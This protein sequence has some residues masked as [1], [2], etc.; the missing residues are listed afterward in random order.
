MCIRDSTAG[1]GCASTSM[2]CSQPCGR[3]AALRT[4]ARRRRRRALGSRNVEAGAEAVQ[5]IATSFLGWRN[6]ANESSDYTNTLKDLALLVQ[7]VKLYG[8][9]KTCLRR[10]GSQT[11]LTS[12][13]YSS[14]LLMRVPSGVVWTL[15]AWSWIFGKANG[16]GIPNRHW[17]SR[18]NDYLVQEAGRTED[19]LEAPRTFS[20]SLIHI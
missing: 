20:L 12:N 7:E 6:L 14:M 9:V 17:P 19:N 8:H 4:L 18:C 5:P 11:A 2:P 16:E 1:T 3:R 13:A 15:R 10:V